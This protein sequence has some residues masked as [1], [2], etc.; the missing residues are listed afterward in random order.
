[1]KVRPAMLLIENNHVLLMHYRYGETDV[2]GLPGGNPD[3]GE[4]LNQTVIREL[5][6]ELGVEVEI[7]PVAFFGEVMM[8]ESKEDVL[9]VLFLGQLIGGIP[10]LNP[11][12][13]SALAVAWKPISE[14]ATLNL[15][16]NV[17]RQIQSLFTSQNSPGYIGKIDQAFF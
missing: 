12:E 14:L 3:K 2:F 5:Q 13:T 17:G 6:E 9:H 11:A 10:R 1:M 15:Y 8:P 7:G 16:P 4:T